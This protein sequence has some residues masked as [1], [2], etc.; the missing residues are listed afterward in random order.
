MVF[1]NLLVDEQTKSVVLLQTGFEYHHL[2]HGGVAAH[3]TEV[4]GVAQ[5]RHYMPRDHDTPVIIDLSPY[6]RRAKDSDLSL[7]PRILSCQRNQQ[8]DRKKRDPAQCIVSERRIFHR[9]SRV[10]TIEN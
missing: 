1:V 10:G 2:T 9:P 8:K 5:Q 4:G 7:R 6:S 3:A